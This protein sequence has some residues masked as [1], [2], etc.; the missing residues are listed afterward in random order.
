MDGGKLGRL[1]GSFG[2]GRHRE[3]EDDLARNGET[4]SGS[5][6]LSTREEEAKDVSGREEAKEVKEAQSVSPGAQLPQQRQ[7]EQL[8][9]QARTV[10]PWDQLNTVITIHRDLT[11]VEP[12]PRTGDDA[13]PEEEKKPPN[14]PQ[15]VETTLHT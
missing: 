10:G 5:V 4:I 9:G 11:E 13:V 2:R 7:D 12:V 6:Q 3:P 15:E 14:T 8:G 1:D